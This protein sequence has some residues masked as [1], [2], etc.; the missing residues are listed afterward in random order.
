MPYFV[1]KITV[2]Q[3]STDTEKTITHLDTFEESQ[4]ARHY[5]RRLRGG[6]ALN[7]IEKIEMVHADEQHQ[8]EQLLQEK[9]ETVAMGKEK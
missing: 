9:E 3:T 2:F 6:L 8:A 7:G 4:E 1:F 5:A